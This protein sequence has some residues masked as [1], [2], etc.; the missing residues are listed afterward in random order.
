MNIT[1]ATKNTLKDISRYI[2]LKLETASLSGGPSGETV[3]KSG[4]GQRFTVD[5]C[6]GVVMDWVIVWT[7]VGVHG[8]ELP[9]SSFILLVARIA[10]T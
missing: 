5:V 9:S 3:S 7:H 4:G 8:A 6:R 2:T 1:D 10:L